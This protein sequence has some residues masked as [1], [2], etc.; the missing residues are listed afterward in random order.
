MKEIQPISIWYNGNIVEATQF[1][2][3]SVSDN[4][5]TTAIFE[6]WLTDIIGITYTSGKLTMEGQDYITYSTSSD[7]NSYAFNWGA[8]KLNLTII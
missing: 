2:L 5:S 6:F 1:W 8:T 7:S 3:N 4:L